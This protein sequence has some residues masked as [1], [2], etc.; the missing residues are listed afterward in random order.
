MKRK[1]VLTVVAFLLVLQAQTVFAEKNNPNELTFIEAFRR[2]DMTE[3]ENILRQKSYQMDLSAL[4]ETVFWNFIVAKEYE[5]RVPLNTD[6]RLLVPTFQLLIKYGVVV[7]YNVS[8]YYWLLKEPPNIWTGN[9]QLTELPRI[10]INDV[11]RKFSLLYDIVFHHN[12]FINNNQQTKLQ[13]A[14]L[15]LEAGA[16]PNTMDWYNLGRENESWF[17]DDQIALARLF[18]EHGLDINRPTFGD[19]YPLYMSV[20]RG[21]FGCV[22]LLVESGAKVNQISRINPRGNGYENITAA[23]EAHRRGEIDIYNY[24]KQN[25]ATWS[26]PSQVATA[27]PASSR[28]RQTYDDSYDYSPPPSS[29]SRSSG[30]SSSSSSSSSGSGW[31][32]FGKALNESLQSPLE[33]GTY[34]MAGTNAR[35][36][37]TAIG[38]SG[39]IMY[40]TRDNRRGTGSYSING[41]TM[42]VQI[43]GLTDVYTITSKT[44]FTG[45]DG[46]L[47]VRTGY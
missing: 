7:N 21:Q 31:A 46:S 30:S 47:W 27:P 35:V 2:S 37:F 17:Y 26:P 5:G 20:V 32:E 11:S 41:N 44:S 24:L 45:R 8:Y 13:L 34:G 12:S 10:Y 18:I 28:P 40:V 9:L 29:S 42:T 33:S 4:L 3:M 38:K 6:I 19:I 16:D 23:Q 39:I 1:T 22:R 43:E 36:T 15:L 25:G 14:R